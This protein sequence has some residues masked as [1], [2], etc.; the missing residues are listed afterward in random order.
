MEAPSPSAMVDAVAAAVPTPGNLPPSS[1]VAATEAVL[2]ESGTSTPTMAEIDSNPTTAEGIPSGRPHV[3]AT[4][5]LGVNN[6][7]RGTHRHLLHV[8]KRE[9]LPETGKRLEEAGGVKKRAESKYSGY[10]AQL[11]ADVGKRAGGAGIG[12]EYC[13]DGE[14][15][16][17]QRSQRPGIGNLLNLLG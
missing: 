7:A 1:H 15:A 13:T 4:H 9:Q 3:P 16:R 2:P 6:R 11:R 8:P 5:R 12:V 14:E 17:R 10:L